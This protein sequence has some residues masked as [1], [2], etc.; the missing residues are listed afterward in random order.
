V[1]TVQT[2]IVAGVATLA[3]L[4][5]AE[6]HDDAIIVLG[7]LKIILSQNRIARRLGVSRKRHVFL[8]DMRRRP[9]QLH[10]RTVAL[11]TPRQRILAFTLLVIL[12]VVAAAASAVLLSLPHGLRSQP[13]ELFIG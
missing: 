3:D 13:I 4:L 8:G 2:T 9:A 6:S 12:I 7:V 10:I 11:K 5:F 1:L